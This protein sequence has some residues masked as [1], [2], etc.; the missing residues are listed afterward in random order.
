MATIAQFKLVAAVAH[1]AETSG[2]TIRPKRVV[3]KSTGVRVSCDR[4]ADPFKFATAGIADANSAIAAG[5]LTLSLSPLRPLRGERAIS[6]DGPSATNSPRPALPR[7]VGIKKGR[8]LALPFS[9]A[10][11]RQR[12]V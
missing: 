9:F 4:F 5:P 8:A 6:C 1:S 3:P 10:G 7:G 2:A 12:S 11:D